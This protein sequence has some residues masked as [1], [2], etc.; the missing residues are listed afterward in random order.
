MEISFEE[1]LSWWLKHE[2]VSK[3]KARRRWR[4]AGTA[5]LSGGRMLS[6]DDAGGH[7]SNSRQSP[8]ASESRSQARDTAEARTMDSPGRRLQARKISSSDPSTATSPMA[9]GGGAA[10]CLS[11]SLD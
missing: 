10:G 11:L 5:V 7:C 1:F 6:S 8:S 9:E 2:A 3:G 4:A